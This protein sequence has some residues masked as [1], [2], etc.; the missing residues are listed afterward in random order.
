MKLAIAIVNV[1]FEMMNCIHWMMFE[2]EIQVAYSMLSKLMKAFQDNYFDVV[3]EEN[4]LV[5]IRTEMK[6]NSTRKSIEFCCLHFFQSASEMMKQVNSR[7]VTMLMI[8]HSIDLVVSLVIVVLMLM[9]M[10]MM[11]LMIVQW[12][13]TVCLYL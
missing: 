10:M 4:L 13:S 3:E 7:N 11:M 1:E 8:E 9:M 6:S 5:V 12:S 2:F